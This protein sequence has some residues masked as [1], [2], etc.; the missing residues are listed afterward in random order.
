M[1]AGE[2]PHI[3]SLGKK[4]LI[5]RVNNRDILVVG[6]EDTVVTS[7]SI[8]EELDLALSTNK[9]GNGLGG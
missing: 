4:V 3:L 8:G 5:A 1:G 9:G 6:V 2:D 7:G